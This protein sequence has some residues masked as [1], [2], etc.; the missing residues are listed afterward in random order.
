MRGVARRVWSDRSLYPP[1]AYVCLTYSIN[2]PPRW[3]GDGAINPD[4]HT[5]LTNTPQQ[6]GSFD[7]A[8]VILSSLFNLSYVILVNLV[9]T[10]IIAGA[11]FD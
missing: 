3:K 4:V 8:M 7:F 9:L 5:T 2:T 1:P 6:Q 11:C 10:A